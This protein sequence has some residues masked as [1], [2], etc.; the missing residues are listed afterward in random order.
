MYSFLIV[1]PRIHI[2]TAQAFSKIVPTP[3]PVNLAESIMLPVENWKES[4]K[5]RFRRTCFF[6]LSCSE[7]NQKLAYMKQVHYMLQ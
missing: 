1:N 3:A 7:T 6:L 4:D 5:K 2:G